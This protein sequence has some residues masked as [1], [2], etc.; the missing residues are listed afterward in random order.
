MYLSTSFSILFSNVLFLPLCRNS[1]K[2]DILASN[3]TPQL[4]YL[5]GT[6]GQ[7]SER[8]STLTKARFSPAFPV[9]NFLLVVHQFSLLINS[10]PTFPPSLERT[11]ISDFPPEILTSTYLGAP[12]GW[13]SSAASSLDP[14]PSD[15]D[16]FSLHV[17]HF[18][19]N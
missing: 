16:Q 18:L 17:I 2:H 3:D 19:Q 7:R 14:D 1:L 11:L 15:D 8:Y 12:S 10:Y 5:E 13:A 9:L 6:S 4:F